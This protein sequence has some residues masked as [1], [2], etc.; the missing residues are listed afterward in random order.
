MKDSFITYMYNNIVLVLFFMW[1]IISAIFEYENLVFFIGFFILFMSALMYGFFLNLYIKKKYGKINYYDDSPQPLSSMIKILLSKNYKVTDVKKI[2]F[3]T[4]DLKEAY[5][6]MKS[7]T[8]KMIDSNKNIELNIIGYGKKEE[9]K[10]NNIS[11]SC[12]PIS[13]KITEHKNLIYMNDEKVFLWYEPNHKTEKGKHY[14][15]HGG[16]FIEP[17]EKA[18]NSIEKEISIFKKELD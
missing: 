8:T 6:Y 16:Y 18:L 9:C 5:D 17:S 3:M 4:Y 12:F 11:L 2:D 14:F 7:A 15:Q 1:L 13:K 10:N